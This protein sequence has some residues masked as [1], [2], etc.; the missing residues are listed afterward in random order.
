[1]PIEGPSLW[2][3]ARTFC[4][5][6]N[7]VFARTITQARVLP[8]GRRRDL[9]ERI[10]IAFRSAGAAQEAPLGTKFGRVGL[11]IGQYCESV[12]TAEKRHRLITVKYRYTLTPDGMTDPLF[13]WEY[14]RSIEGPHCRHHLQGAIALSFG[15][16]EVSLNDLHLPTAYV[17]IEHVI[18]FCIADLGVEPLSRDWEA[19]LRESH[20]KF[21][22]EF[23]A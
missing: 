13:R 4:E 21:E 9:T 16:Q 15:R 11:Y 8:I 20:E 7:T 5:H 22:T 12:L 19:I 17:P 14:D 2:N 3:A 18:R 10:Q 1:M 6:L 23:T